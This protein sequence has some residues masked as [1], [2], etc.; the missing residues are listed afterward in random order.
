MPCDP[1]DEYA[2]PTRRVMLSHLILLFHFLF[3][4]D[5]QP[6]AIRNLFTSTPSSEIKYTDEYRGDDVGTKSKA[7]ESFISLAM[8]S[9]SET[10]GEYK[11]RVSKTF[12]FKEQDFIAL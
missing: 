9:D 3:S 7:E 11:G 4:N 1:V 5:S 10:K 2:R 12:S 8:S 6:S